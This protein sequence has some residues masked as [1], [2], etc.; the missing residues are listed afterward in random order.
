M[1]TVVTAVVHKEHV[2]GD[3]REMSAV[4]HLY[5]TFI[6][7]VGAIHR[8]P[9]QRGGMDNNSVALLEYMKRGAQIKSPINGYKV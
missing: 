5:V 2:F 8:L 7:I 9:C 6:V 1:R 4:D 3:L